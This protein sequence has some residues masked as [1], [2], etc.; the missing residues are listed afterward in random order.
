MAENFAES[1]DLHVTFGKLTELVRLKVEQNTKEANMIQNT[2]N[3]EN[4]KQ[5]RESCCNQWKGKITLFRHS[6]AKIFNVRNIDC[7]VYWP[8]NIH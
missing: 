1:D 8:I 2:G 4:N 3:S 7:V 5:E 6:Y